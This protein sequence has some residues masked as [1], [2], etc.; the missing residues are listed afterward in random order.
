MRLVARAE[1]S[2]FAEIAKRRRPEE[3][4]QAE[5][6]G[7]ATAHGFYFIM[8]RYKGEVEK[9]WGLSAAPMSARLELRPRGRSVP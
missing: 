2:R 5:Q 9:I 6:G 4:I 7:R 1:E 8:E 3:K